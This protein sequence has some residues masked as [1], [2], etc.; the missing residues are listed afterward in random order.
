MIENDIVVG[1]ISIGDITKYRLIEKT[2]ENNVLQDLARIRLAAA[3]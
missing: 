1:L 3:A 2:E